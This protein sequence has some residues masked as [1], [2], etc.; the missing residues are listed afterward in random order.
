MLP[1][2]CLRAPLKRNSLIWHTLAAIL[3]VRHPL[4]KQPFA[5]VTFTSTIGFTW[6]FRR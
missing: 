4:R 1:T 5:G 3:P 6:N 2:R